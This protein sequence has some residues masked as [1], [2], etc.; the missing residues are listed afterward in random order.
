MS[1]YPTF[2]INS[3]QKRCNEDID[4]FSTQNNSSEK[5]ENIKTLLFIQFS[6]YDDIEKC[7]KNIIQNFSDV[8]VTKDIRFEN[9]DYSRDIKKFENETLQQKIWILRTI[10]FYQISI[11][12]SFMMQNKI[13]FGEVYDKKTD[14]KRDFKKMDDLSKFEMAIFGKKSVTSDIDVSIVNNSRESECLSYIISILEDLFII[15]TGKKSLD[16]DIEFYAS[17]LTVK[18]PDYIKNPK[19][20]SPDIFILDTIKLDKKDFFEILPYAFASVIRNIHLSYNNER[21][22]DESL[23]KEIYNNIVNFVYTKY[24]QYDNELKSIS[25]DTKYLFLNNIL[26]NDNLIN[27]H[28]KTIKDNDLFSYCFNTGL[29]IVKEYLSKNYDDG[30]NKYYEYIKE[31]EIQFNKLK[32][33]FEQTYNKLNQSTDENSKKNWQQIVKTELETNYK[34]LILEI[35]KSSANMDTFRK[36]S[37]V[38]APTVMHVVRVFQETAEKNKDIKYPVNFPQCL[39]NPSHILEGAVCEIGKYGYILSII[40]QIGFVLRFE[41]DYCKKNTNQLYDDI[42]TNKIRKYMERYID[43]INRMNEEENNRMVE[44]KAGKKH[45]TVKIIPK[46][47]AKRTR[48]KKAGKQT[49]GKKSTTKTAK[50]MRS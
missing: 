32:N 14:Y 40:E 2:E 10:L 30:R 21:I 33:I 41:N 42:C 27:I 22:N 5:Y 18:N 29:G 6:N 20:N 47:K 50:K 36:E 46:R 26:N 28:N 37:Y 17:I 15:F 9:F 16:F 3:L 48:G 38:C 4:T 19:E 11:I 34:N 25:K 13:L 23:N 1:V 44:I 7:V 49:R 43:A 24:Y 35:I 12:S 45:R 31:T 8:L 39:N